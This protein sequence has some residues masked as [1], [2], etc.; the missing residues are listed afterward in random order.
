M[1]RKVD[2]VLDDRPTATIDIENHRV[3]AL[4]NGCISFV[5]FIV[6]AF[7]YMARRGDV[8]WEA[9]V[10]YASQ[11]STFTRN[12]TDLNIS[13]KIPIPTFND[14][15][16]INWDDMTLQFLTSHKCNLREHQSPQCDCLYKVFSRNMEPH[17]SINSSNVVARYTGYKKHSVECKHMRGNFN[18]VF[19]KGDFTSPF[20]I[21]LF[22]WGIATLSHLYAAQSSY[23]SSKPVSRIL[24][25]GMAVVFGVGMALF[26]TA[27]YNKLW[28]TI[29]F[30][31]M[32]V[33]SMLF[34][35]FFTLLCD[36]ARPEAK[37]HWYSWS[38]VVGSSFETGI[39]TCV[40]LAASHRLML[41]FSGRN[42]TDENQATL[43]F[44]VITGLCSTMVNMF[45]YSISDMN[46][47]INRMREKERMTE[48]NLKPMMS[49][50]QAISFSAQWMWIITVTLGLTLTFMYPLQPLQHYSTQMYAAK[51]AVG[52]W[53]MFFVLQIPLRHFRMGYEILQE[54]T[55]F[56][57][58]EFLA[59]SMVMGVIVVNFV[60][61]G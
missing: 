23:G 21:A 32:P 41:L 11:I 19:V 49:S 50:L 43:C 1:D 53:C 6:V 14:N 26:L 59:R 16:R 7:W 61:F 28:Y 55:I 10:P 8:A 47:F 40:G 9:R 29:L 54:Y 58:V 24:R 45:N 17:D 35:S 42:D 38:T 51:A 18:T 30:S 48:N 15:G 34:I 4:I 57:V 5:V 39:I 3:L 36:Y 52:L 37:H 44:A 33:A 12:S 56:H 46:D 27:S 25:V 2:P 13:P 20:D 31:V 60:I 22:W